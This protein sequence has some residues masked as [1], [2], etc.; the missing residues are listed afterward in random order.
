MEKKKE[1]DN[2]FTYSSDKGLKV[3]TEQEIL[4]SIDSKDSDKPKDREKK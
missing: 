4:E 3:L 2:R 1:K